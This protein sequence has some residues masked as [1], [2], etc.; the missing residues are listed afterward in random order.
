MF[1]FDT[2]VYLNFYSYDEKTKSDLFSILDKIKNNIWVPNHV[3]LE[4]QRRRLDV[5][6][7]ERENFTKIT[8]VF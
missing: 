5:I 1:V 8:N 7:K 2:N 4:Y 6:D 3:A